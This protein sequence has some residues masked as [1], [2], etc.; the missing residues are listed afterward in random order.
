MSGK[1]QLYWLPSLQKCLLWPQANKVHPGAG[2]HIM[3]I[4]EQYHEHAMSHVNA[5]L[6]QASIFLTLVKFE[7]GP[8]KVVYFAT[9]VVHFRATSHGD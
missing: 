8:V 2:A 9:L 7:A 6:Y 1:L 4:H 5:S 3:N